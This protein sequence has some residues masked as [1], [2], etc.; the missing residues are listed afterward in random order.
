MSNVDEL[1]QRLIEIWNSLQQNIIDAAINDWRKQLRAF[2]HADG[3]YFLRAHVTNKSYGQ[4][5]YKY[6]KKTL[7]Y[8]WTYDFRG[9]KVSQGKVR[10]INRWGG[11]SN[12]LS[13][14]YLFTNIYTKNYRNRTTIVEIIVG[15]LVVS[16]FWY[17]VYLRIC[18][19]RGG[20]DGNVTKVDT[21]M[22]QTGARE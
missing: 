20:G 14:A 5:K 7:L 12:H 11:I 18:S 8:C 9:L 3:Q 21:A 4:I 15:G 22:P 16:F 1:K 10:T 6:L 19:G 2:L 17:T 13:L